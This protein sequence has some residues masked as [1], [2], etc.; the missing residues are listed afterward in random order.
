M[1]AAVVAT[2]LVH[3]A[4][5]R[6]LDSPADE[7]RR[8]E[9]PIATWNH[10]HAPS[11]SPA[12]A[13]AAAVL[14]ASQAGNRAQLEKRGEEV[15]NEERADERSGVRGFSRSSSSNNRAKSMRSWK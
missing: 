3:R 6:A 7:E 15:C 8:G 2:V 10:F 13:A 12:V 5:H 9:A 4:A 11:S 14:A 1:A